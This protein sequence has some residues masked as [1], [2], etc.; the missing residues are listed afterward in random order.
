MKSSMPEPIKLE[1]AL[2]KGP[3]TLPDFS[4]LVKKLSS[5]VVSISVEASSG[6][7]EETKDEQPFPF[8]RRDPYINPR[9]LGSGFVVS[10]DGYI[11]TNNHVISKADRIL[12]RFHDGEEDI[13]A[14]LIGRDDKTDLAL[15]KIK[16]PKSLQTVAVGD[17]ET[18]EVGDWA[19]AIG[20]Q[21]QLGQTV[22]AGIVSAKSRRVPSM[23]SGPYDQFIQTDASINP[24][25]SGGPLFNTRGQVV[26]I[27]TAIFSPARSNTGQGF[28]IGIGFAIPINLAR[29][30]LLQLKEHGR[31]IR[32]LL[33]VIIQAVNKDVAEALGIP[34][35]QGALVADVMKDSPAKKAGFKR[36][37]IIIS[38]DGKKIKEHTDLPLIVART[39]VGKKVDVEVLREGKKIT[40]NP[41]IDE[42]KEQKLSKDKEKPKTDELGLLVRDVTKELAESLGM[43]EP[44]GVVV[45]E[46]E[47]G[48]PASI[49]RISR[50]DI[51]EEIGGKKVK[52]KKSFYKIVD[53]LTP[54]KP[55]LVLIRKKEGTRFVTLKPP[56]KEESEEK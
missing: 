15:I 51:I 32:G 2:K 3:D 20:N 39:P 16:P 30:V 27:N 41:R 42:M 28:N 40:L 35:Q 31:V 24:G 55:V 47:A 50:G 38:F 26:G 19:I 23:Q 43:E 36:K 29:E 34:E 14:E 52:D 18:V 48:S 22:T 12:V 37:D 25:S 6:Q 56:A 46:V 54:D 45:D 11:V 53:A 49:A 17:S 10:P 9:A 33:G 4:E 21:F 44:S 8:F 1:G 7:D 5:T 13:A